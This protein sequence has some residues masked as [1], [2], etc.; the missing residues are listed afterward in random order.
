[1]VQHTCVNISHN[2]VLGSEDKCSVGG[3]KRLLNTGNEVL[4][5]H[6]F[7]SL[8]ANVVGPLLNC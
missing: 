3:P 1:M 7:C 6:R 5:T 8:S 2:Y 4:K